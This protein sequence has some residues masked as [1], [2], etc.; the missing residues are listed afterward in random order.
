MK[1]G[2]VTALNERPRI[3][4]I[5]LNCFERLRS[6]YSSPH[7][8]IEL[9]AAVHNDE[10]HALV[11]EYGGTAIKCEGNVA[12]RQTVVQVVFHRLFGDGETHSDGLVVV[13]SGPGFLRVVVG[14]CLM[15]GVQLA[16]IAAQRFSM[17]MLN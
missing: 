16:E 1:L 14:N 12:G 8:P 4:R 15:H 10:D 2:I 5:M 3:S 13:T 11:E 6:E 17:L 7:S 9:F